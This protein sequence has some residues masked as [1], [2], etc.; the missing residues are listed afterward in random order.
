MNKFSIAI[1]GGAGTI[2]PALMTPQ[3]ELLYRQALTDAIAAG[4]AILEKGG[5]AID[6]VEAAVVSLEN[7]PLFNAGKGAVFTNKGTHEMDAAIM[8]GLNLEAGAVSGVSS[9]Q[10]PISLA[11][12]VMEKS[13]HVF[14]SGTE[15]EKFA[16]LQGLPFQLPEYFYIEERYKQWQD[17]KDSDSYQLDHTDKTEQGEKKFGTVGAV[18]RDVHGNLAAATST[19]GMTNKKFGRIGDTPIIGSGTYANNN[20]CAI[21]CTGHGEYFIRAVVAYDIS[22]LM[23][24]KGLSLAEACQMVVQDKLVKMGGEGGLVAI[25][26]HGNI[27]LPFNS[28]GMYRAWQY[29]GESIF[30]A[31]YK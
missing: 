8:N 26:K 18:A 21:S 12:L 29:A 14:L 3:K 11:R 20:T 13:G 1:H 10:N 25:D 5:S 17:L 28:E 31:I 19:G 22:C 27:E 2:L 24:Y 7:F 23:E 30:T 9:I 6:A 4:A 16:K 15:A